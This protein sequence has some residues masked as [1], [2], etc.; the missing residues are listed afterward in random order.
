MI[1]D[2]FGNLVWFNAIGNR[3][4]AT[5]FR[6]QTYLGKPVLTWWQGRL[7]GGEGRGEGVI[8]DTRYRPVA[9]RARRQR[10]SAPTCTSSSS[11]RRG[12][13]LLLIYDAVRRDL[14]ERR[15][16]PPTASSS[17]PSCRRSTSPPGWCCSSGTASATSGSRSRTSRVP[18][19]GG[20]WDYVHANSV[21]LDARRGLHRL[22][23]PHLVRATDLARDAAGSCGGWA[24]RARTSAWGRAT[25]FWQPARRAPAARRHAD[26]VRQQRAAAAAQGARARSRSRLDTERKTATLRAGA[27]AP[28]QPAL[29]DPGRRAAAAERRDVRRLGLAPLLHRVRRRG[30]RRARRAASPSAATTTAPTS[31]P[32]SGRPAR[33]PALVA[34]RR[35]N[36]VAARVSWN[37]ATG[38]ASWELWA[39]SSANALR[40]IKGQPYG[41]FETAI[42]ARRRAARFVQVRALDAAGAVL[43]A[44]RDDP[45]RFVRALTRRFPPAIFLTIRPRR[46]RRGRL[47]TEAMA[48]GHSP[49]YTGLGHGARGR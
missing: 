2:D 39:G 32:W 6:V 41:G 28:R 20:H 19:R 13:A 49:R 27:H 46:R 47:D 38:V 14:R 34:S 9:A 7:I 5:D 35:G 31:F 43:G 16:Q 10:A 30:P 29:R 15:R 25:R 45:D 36:R 3:E 37:G 12:T 23:A 11:R 1:V 48:R 21:A 33:P 44:E 26:A 4:L 17:R 8:Y 42:S 22:R 40:R 18:E 24:A